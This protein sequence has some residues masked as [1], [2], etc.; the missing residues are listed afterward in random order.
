VQRVLLLLQLG[1]LHQQQQ[2]PAGHAAR[3]HLQQLQ[4]QQPAARRQLAQL[5]LPS[6][7]TRRQME[8]LQLQ[9]LQLQPAH[10]A[11][12]QLPPTSLWRG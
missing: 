5:L 11:S 2:L 10:R 12:H 8:S 6:V 7:L 1:L 9:R 3:R 4:L